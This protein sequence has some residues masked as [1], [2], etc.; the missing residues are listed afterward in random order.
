[1]KRHLKKFITVTSALLIGCFVF[2]MQDAGAYVMKKSTAKLSVKEG[3][4]KKIKLAGKA[5][6]AVKNGKK[7]IKVKSSN[8]KVVK[9]TRTK[10][11]KKK[12][13][14]T[15]KGLKKGN[16]VVTVKYKKK[17]IKLKVNVTEAV[18]PTPNVTLSLIH[19]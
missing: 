2:N 19:I 7:T 9:V 13:S 17:G 18:Q 5:L 14:F 3:Q 12:Y 10:A 15:I 8:K 4:S 11:Q 1:M 16:A 6:K